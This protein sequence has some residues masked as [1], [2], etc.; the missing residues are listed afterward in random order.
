MTGSTKGNVQSPSITSSGKGKRANL[1]SKIGG[2]TSSLVDRK[3][4]LIADSPVVS[5]V[6]GGGV[7][8][9]IS[10]GSLTDSTLTANTVD[11]L[12]S[13]D[14]ESL[15]LLFLLKWRV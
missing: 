7:G 14:V 1:I 10:E 15:F 12:R 4:L 13:E 2:I 11:S 6:G 5:S 3:R 8:D 9:T